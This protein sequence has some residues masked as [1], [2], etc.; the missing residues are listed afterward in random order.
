M[1]F[2][3]PPTRTQDWAILIIVMCNVSRYGGDLTYHVVKF[4]M[5]GQSVLDK[6]PTIKIKSPTLIVIMYIRKLLYTCMHM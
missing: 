4:P 6:Y 1:Y 2:P 3:L 5:M